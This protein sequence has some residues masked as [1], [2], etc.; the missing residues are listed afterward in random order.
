MPPPKSALPA[1]QVAVA[2]T[3]VP[4]AAFAADVTAVPVTI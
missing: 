4:A 2:V 1:G 3:I